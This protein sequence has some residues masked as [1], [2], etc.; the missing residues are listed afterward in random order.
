[1]YSIWL[2]AHALGCYRLCHDHT[3]FW[4]ISTCAYVSV[5]APCPQCVHGATSICV[6]SACVYAGH[7]TMPSMCSWCRLNVGLGYMYP[8]W[9][10]HH[11]F[12]VFMVLPQCGSCQHV[13]ILVTAPCLLNH[14]WP[15][16]TEQFG[17]NA[18]VTYPTS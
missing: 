6:M 15:G 10:R 9:S 2:R 12:N 5:T 7:G 1:M 16:T 17:I 14:V 3:S 8:C 18:T 4:I 13:S 11:A